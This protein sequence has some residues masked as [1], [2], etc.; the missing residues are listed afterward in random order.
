MIHDVNEVIQQG[1]MSRYQK[2]AITICLAINMLDGFDVLVMAFTA[3]SVA[4]EWGLQS[5]ELGIL[6]SAGLLGMSLGSLFVAPRADRFGRRS[7]VL[8]C[9]VI[10]S[11]GMFLSAVSQSMVQLAMLRLI[12]GL[13]IGGLLASLN[14]IVAEYSSI[15]WREFAVSFLQ[16]G[17][18]IGAVIGGSIAVFLIGEY[19]WRSVFLFGAI[20]SSLL[21]PLTFQNLPESLAFLLTKRPRNALEKVNR[22]LGHMGHAA[23]EMLP[24]VP[25]GA[26]LQ[27]TG[28]RDLVSGDLRRSSLMIWLA[29]FML[30]LS[31][32]FVLSWTPKLLTEAGLSAGEGISAG[33][34]LNLGGI[35]G[36][37]IL[38]YLTTKLPLRF[39][40]GAYM[41]VTA[42]FMALFSIYASNMSLALVLCVAIGFF[43]FGSMI[44]LY[45]LVPGLYPV[46][47]RTTGMGWAIGIGRGGA[48]LSPLAAGVLLDYQWQSN[49]LFLI[50]AIPLVIAMVAVSAAKSAARK[51]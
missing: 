40:I 38:G 19:G 41:I 36:G 18:P 23:V 28:V 49:T 30:M 31:F 10:I 2:V 12:T 8:S 13:G 45:A 17:Y 42:V 4:S 47:I 15:K 37:L 39:L 25:T 21:I 20:M 14:V 11:V 24:P 51:N 35:V 22:L 3:S 6:F 26:E 9:L 29:F 46:S 27:L 44:G 7:V 16:T 32:Y 50:F 33:V 48:V 43:L 1:V 34:L 5:S